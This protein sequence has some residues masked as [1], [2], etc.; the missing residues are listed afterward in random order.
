MRIGQGDEKSAAVGRITPSILLKNGIDLIKWN[1]NVMLSTPTISELGNAIKLGTVDAV[2][3]WNATAMDYK[4][5]AE[6]IAIDKNKNVIPAVEAAVLT[7]T[8]D[9]YKADDFLS[10]LTGPRGISIMVEDGFS[11]EK[12]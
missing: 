10:Y 5:D 12:P 9:K 4:N 8:F 2:I 3:V 11:V 1:K 6:V 7:T